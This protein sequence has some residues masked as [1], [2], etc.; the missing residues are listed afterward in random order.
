MLASTP[1]SIPSGPKVGIWVLADVPWHEYVVL[2]SVL[3]PNSTEEL[4]SAAKAGLTPAA[5]CI[6]RH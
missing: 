1:V 2:L 6:A 5:T 3:L 4:L